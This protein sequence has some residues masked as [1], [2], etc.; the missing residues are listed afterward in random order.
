MKILLVEDDEIFGSSLVD[1]LTTYS[2]TVEWVADGQTGWDYAQATN[3]DLIILDWDLPNLDGKALCQRLRQAQYAGAI[4]LLTSKGDERFKVAGLDAGAD[5]YVVK[6]CT[7][8]ELVARLRA[9]LRR[10]RDLVDTVLVWGELQLDL[11]ACQVT[12]STEPLA[13]SPKEYSLLEI[14]LRNPQRV[15]SSAVLLERLWTFEEIPGEDTVRT[16][17]KRLRRKLK[18]VGVTGVIENIYGMG[19][20]LATLPAERSDSLD[21]ALEGERTPVSEETAMVPGDPSSPFGA[22]PTPVA[23]AEVS[24]LEES[25]ATADS[26][27]PPA[28]MAR[29]AAMA[30]LGQFKS[31]L[32]DRIAHLEAAS[33][34][35]M[36]APG[37]SALQIEPLL[38]EDLRQPAQQAAHKLAGSLGMFGL[39][40]ESHQCKVLEA[41][42]AAGLVDPQL[43]AR[44][45][46][47]L[48]Q[49]LQSVLDPAASTAA[50]PRGDAIKG[51]D[52][53][54]RAPEAATLAPP[55][56]IL[57]GELLVVTSRLD[58]GQQ[59]Q[60][61]A[62]PTLAIAIVQSWSQAQLILGE[63]PRPVLLD[64]GPDFDQVA[65]LAAYAQTPAADPI[66]LLPP[67]ADVLPLRRAL[68]P[69]RHC[70][71]LAADLS[72]EQVV[73][74][75]FSQLA[76]L[77][78][79]RPHI[80]AVDDDPLVLG[81]LI[82]QLTDA[83]MVVTTLDD[84]LQFW[85]FLAHNRPDLLILDIE[86]PNLEGVELC[87]MVR[88]DRQW[89]Q[90]PILFLTSRHGPNI[91]QQVY[92]AGADDYI[93]KPWNP[94]Y[95]TTRIYNR[96]QRQQTA[97]PG[98]WGATWGY[99]APPQ[100]LKTFQRDLSLAQRH[101]QPYCLALLRLQPLTT[102]EVSLPLA[103]GAVQGLQGK[104]RREDLLLQV[105]AYTL[106]LG[107]YGLP[108]PQASQRLASL[109]AELAAA[110]PSADK[111][112]MKILSGYAIAPDEGTTLPLLWTLASQKL[113]KALTHA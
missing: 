110:S 53:R 60:A 38:P 101:R 70:T 93:L 40:A 102:A 61:L 90:L 12:V 30:A 25:E 71:F 76:P 92:A 88:R 85:T 104:L 112:E 43:L 75:V 41:H 15:F 27:V 36:S 3:Y 107:L 100:V 62:P 32:E 56:P 18:R 31:V 113:Q 8:A 91:R 66:W 84:P 87:Q 81:Q 2:Y 94:D 109:T 21:V 6:S 48:R 106:L 59:L 46:Q 35:L 50:E 10:P 23:A 89:A 68:A 69:H 16:H 96:I 73:T 64:L 9:L 105:D 79:S 34:A 67:A 14:F 63:H 86:M 54:P 52:D 33:M 28:A 111:G 57:G 47:Q 11:N 65:A 77:P 24:S 95:L 5:D 103:P 13:L 17:I 82:Q 22:V 37:G 19:Y 1:T 4:L 58:W 51:G 98:Y 83:G 42:L 72:P 39:T 26:V 97:T 45:V 74:Q 44:V 7:P 20:R 29:A 49:S 99:L 55:Q 80:L 108:A 78:P